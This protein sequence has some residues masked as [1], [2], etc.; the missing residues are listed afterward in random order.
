MTVLKKKK[1]A[2]ILV[3]S[4]KEKQTFSLHLLNLLVHFDKL[5]KICNGGIKHS[6]YGCSKQ[7]KHLEYAD[8]SIPSIK[9][10]DEPNFEWKENHISKKRRIKKKQKIKSNKFLNDNI[11]WKNHQT[12][13]S[14]SKRR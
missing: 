4:S 7:W 1:N 13:I 5:G 2:K 12:K 10:S 8:Y 14:N 3:R 6:V 9:D 11:L